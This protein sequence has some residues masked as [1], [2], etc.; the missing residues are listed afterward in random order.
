VLP[1]R[2]RVAGYTETSRRPFSR[3]AGGCRGRSLQEAAQAAGYHARPGHAVESNRP[4]P[5]PDAMARGLTAKIRQILWILNQSFPSSNK[6]GTLPY[7]IMRKLL[8]FFLA[9]ALRRIL[10]SS[11]SNG[12]FCSNMAIW[13]SQ[14]GLPLN[15][16]TRSIR[17]CSGSS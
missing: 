3:P 11:S 8:L 6:P 1:E 15:C 16:S 13:Y 17:R 9:L 14:Y 4:R 12:S 10:L 5:E 2:R 7:L